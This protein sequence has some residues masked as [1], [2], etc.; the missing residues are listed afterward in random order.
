MEQEKEQEWKSLSVRPKVWD[1]VRDSML[2]DE[3]YGEWCLRAVK[4]L[5]VKQ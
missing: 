2:R 4:A 3:T 1:K 5:E